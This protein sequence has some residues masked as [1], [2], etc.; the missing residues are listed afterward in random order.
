MK[1]YTKRGDAGETDLFGGQR[2]LKNVPRVEAFGTV[3]ELNAALGVV[4]AE[5]DADRDGDLM[6]LLDRI[7]SDLFVVGGDLATPLEDDGR[8]MESVVAR[9]SEQAATRLE[10]EIDR[11][12]GELPPLTAFI[13]PGGS[14]AGAHLHVA[15]TVCRRAERAAVALAAV[16]VMNADV[17][18][19]LNRLADLLFVLSRSVNRRDGVAEVEWHPSPRS[20]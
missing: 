12:E 20:G 7:Q 4:C 2:V 11:I 10:A 16:D 19:Y 8:K 15:R 18:T 13:L 1:I 3:D 6:Q 14:R 17:I 5:L 9:I